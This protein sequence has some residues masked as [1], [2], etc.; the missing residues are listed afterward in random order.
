MVQNNT[1]SGKH[2]FPT[3]ARGL[4]WILKK[5]GQMMIA[6]MALNADLWEQII[7]YNNFML[8]EYAMNELHVRRNE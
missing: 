6:G 8:L 3:T 2:V 1:K 7:N 5:H 4:E